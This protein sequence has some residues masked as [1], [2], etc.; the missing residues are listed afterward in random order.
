M[1]TLVGDPDALTRYSIHDVVE[2]AG[3]QGVEVLNWIAMRGALTGT[4]TRGAP[5]LPHP[6]L[7]HGRGDRAAREPRGGS[8]AA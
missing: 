7:E 2:Q 4:V 6:H 5:Q 8:A 1:D 3:S